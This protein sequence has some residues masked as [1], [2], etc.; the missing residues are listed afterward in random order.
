[1][2]E[3]NHIVFQVHT[4]D[5]K[6]HEVSVNKSGKSWTASAYVDGRHVEGRPAVTTQKAIENWESIYRYTFDT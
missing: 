3:T 2:Q 1:M 4:F 6:D 5:G